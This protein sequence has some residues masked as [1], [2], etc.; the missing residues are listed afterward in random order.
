MKKYG[1]FYTKEDTA[2]SY[3]TLTSKKQ[4]VVASPKTIFQI[5]MTAKTLTLKSLQNEVNLF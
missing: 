5:K 4:K 2:L 3:W 1:H